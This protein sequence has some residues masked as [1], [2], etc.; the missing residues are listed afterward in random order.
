MPILENTPTRLSIKSGATIL[1]L[2]KNN[3]KVV[4]Q[5]KLIFWQRKPIEKALSEIASISVDA[6]V[7]RASG[8]EICHTMVILTTGDAWALPA[9][10]K[11]EAQV[12]AIFSTYR[13]EVECALS[14]LPNEPLTRHGG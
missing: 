11:N 13:L 12:N 3:G 2:N 9:A 7:D 10:D 8:V 4:L 6:G 5:R 14:L 1:T